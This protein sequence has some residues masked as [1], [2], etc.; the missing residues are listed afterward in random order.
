MSE[1]KRKELCFISGCTNT[2]ILDGVCAECYIEIDKEIDR[3]AVRGA[4]NNADNVNDASPYNTPLPDSFGEDMQHLLDR[5]RGIDA[6]L[7]FHWSE[8]E[9]VFKMSIWSAVNEECCQPK[10]CRDLPYLIS[11]L[12]EHL[13][14]VISKHMRACSA[15]GCRNNTLL[16]KGGLLNACDY[17]YICNPRGENR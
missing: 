17:C 6:S 11:R 15:D 8:P 9:G 3:Q 1:K 4:V 2:P 7:S 16:S 5:C 10:G 12:N 14:K 13:D